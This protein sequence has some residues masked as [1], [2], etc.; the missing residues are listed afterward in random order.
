MEAKIIRNEELLFSSIQIHDT[1]C[2]RLRGLMF[3]KAF[4]SAGI[5]LV[6]CR[7]IHTFFMSFPID[8]V[9]LDR[10][11]YVKD[12]LPSLKPGKVSKL[13]RDCYQVLELPPESIERHRIAKGN[14]LEIIKS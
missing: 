13:Y 1:F 11:G 6:P 2:K 8:V 14:R 9:F 7:Q 10:E 4:R 3:Q 12:V 5:L